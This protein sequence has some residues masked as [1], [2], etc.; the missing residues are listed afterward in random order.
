MAVGV[1]F[2]G[3]VGI[4]WRPV[5]GGVGTNDW[6]TP[7]HYSHPSYSS[8]SE[9]V[10]EFV[11]EPLVGV[12]LVVDLQHLAILICGVD[13]AIVGQHTSLTIKRFPIILPNSGHA[14][15]MTGSTLMI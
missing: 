4:E 2:E 14:V 15:R 10:V 5:D 3:M 8:H 1:E 6:V 7:F 11:S 12:R 13:A 9:P